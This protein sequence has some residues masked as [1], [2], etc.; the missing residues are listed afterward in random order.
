MASNYSGKFVGV[1]PSGSSG[2]YTFLPAPSTYK[3]TA[4]TLVDSARNSEG[5]VIGNVIRSGVRK[6]EMS[7]NF[8]TQEQ[9]SLIAQL[10]EGDD[11]FFNEVIYYDTITGQMETKQMYVGDRVSDSAQIVASYDN[12]GNITKINGYANVSLS[13]IEV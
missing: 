1:R 9:Y 7:W 6:V 4:S 13:L 5:F 2:N 10:F 12:N 3:M 11:K 8:L